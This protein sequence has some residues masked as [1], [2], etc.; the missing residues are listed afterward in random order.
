M[1]DLAAA[2][3]DGLEIPA[4]LR[5]AKRASPPR[6]RRW[7]RLAPR[8][9]DGEKWEKAERWEITLGLEHSRTGSSGRAVGLA[10]GTRMVWVIEGTKWAELRD[11]EDFLKLPI[12]EWRR[13]QRHGRAVPK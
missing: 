7:K 9:P 5:S 4:F 13:L 10:S 12:A 3:P 6:E 11:A 8:R 2:I 1:S